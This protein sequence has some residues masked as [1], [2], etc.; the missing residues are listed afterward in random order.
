MH[1]VK[2]WI[3]AVLVLQMYLFEGLLAISVTKGLNRMSG[4]KAKLTT[5][6]R[7]CVISLY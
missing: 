4:S 1:L 7:G 6:V 2:I 5:V 3:H